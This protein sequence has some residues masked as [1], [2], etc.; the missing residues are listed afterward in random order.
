MALVLQTLLWLFLCL[1][2]SAEAETKQ[3]SGHEPSSKLQQVGILN[4]V[5][6][7]KKRGYKPAWMALERR[8]RTAVLN[9][10]DD[11]IREGYLSNENA[12]LDVHMVHE[13]LRRLQQQFPQEIEMWQIA[14]THFGF[15]V[16]AVLVGESSAREKMDVLHLGSVHGN[17]LLTINYTLDALEY[18]LKSSTENVRQLRERFN[19]WFVPLVNPDGNWLSMR[20]AHANSYGKKNGRNTDGT[21]ETFGYEGVDISKN[22]PHK[23]SEE[24]LEPETQGLVNLITSRRFIAALSFHSG[25]NGVLTPSLKPTEKEGERLVISS[26]TN[27]IAQDHPDLAIAPLNRKSEVREIVWMHQEQGIPALIYDYPADIAPMSDVDRDEARKKTSQFIETFWQSLSQRSFVTGVV[28]DQ[29]GKPVQA[30]I[31]LE[32][33]ARNVHVW[34]TLE[35]GNFALIFPAKEVFTLHIDMDGYVSAQK[36]IDLRSGR[37]VTRIVLRRKEDVQTDQID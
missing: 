10:D 19:L 2:S 29:D 22:F 18:V 32:Q 9:W 25:G 5:T 6:M 3:C 13:R 7:D 17:E 8:Y 12:Y 27:D 14:E 20:R 37:S 4:P 30:Q 15:P 35:D 16:Y 33:E 11:V 23:N 26:F 31:R 24:E 34:E 21:C 1:T 36:K 28:V